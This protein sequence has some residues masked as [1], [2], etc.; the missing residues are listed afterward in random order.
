VSL[1][2]GPILP[3][4]AQFPISSGR[5]R[6]VVTE[7]GAT[8]RGLWYGERPLVLGFEKD[9]SMPLYRGAILAPWPNRIRDGRYTWQEEAHQLPI[10]EP[11]R[12]CALHGLVAWLRW[13]CEAHDEQSVTLTC[14]IW[15]Q[16][17]YPFLVR[18]TVT[19]RLDADGLTVTLSATN[20]GS[21][22]APYGC[23]IHP[24][25]VPGHA[26]VDRWLLRLPASSFVT[27]D[28]DRLL[29]TGQ[30]S[31]AVS[32]FDFRR[33]R[34]IDGAAIDHAFTDLEFDRLG[35]CQASVRDADGF[36]VLMTWDRSCGWVQVHTADRP[37]IQYHRSG[38]VVEPMTCAPDAFRSGKGLQTLL[39]GSSFRTWWRLAC[40]MPT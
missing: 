2:G 23:S 36:E 6:A 16:P 15:P 7:V 34:R 14:V 32:G 5:Y 8:L 30:E 1:H 9:E 12:Q 22:P 24:Y 28:P 29:P 25:L 21:S 31:V 13:T 33:G 39:P 35:Q 27:V 3:T 11:E 19:F 40:N 37:E 10:N 38:L 4:G 20:H 26:P 17:G 18:L